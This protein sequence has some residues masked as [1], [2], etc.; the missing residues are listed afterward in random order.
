[1]SP[2]SVAEYRGQLSNLDSSPEP[3]PRIGKDGKARK[4]RLARPGCSIERLAK[5]KPQDLSFYQPTQTK[6]VLGQLVKPWRESRA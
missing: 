2:S 6:C 5:V 4:P 1:M 3:Q